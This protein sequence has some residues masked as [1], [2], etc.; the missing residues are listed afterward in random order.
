[1]ETLLVRITCDTCKKV[2]TV[3]YKQRKSSMLSWL[4][5]RKGGKKFNVCSLTCERKLL[6]KQTNTVLNYH[7]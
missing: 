4:C 5:Y 2:E 3:E 6:E 1:M 7:G